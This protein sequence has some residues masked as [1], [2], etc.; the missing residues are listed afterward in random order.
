MGFP[1]KPFSLTVRPF[2]LIFPYRDLQR[3]RARRRDSRRPPSSRNSLLWSL[4]AVTGKLT[5][6]CVR[7][8]PSEGWW[9]T[10]P[11][12]SPGERPTVNNRER[13]RLSEVRRRSSFPSCH[14]KTISYT[15]APAPLFDAARG[16]RQPVVTTAPAP[17]RAPRAP[18]V[19]I[20]AYRQ[21]SDAP[22]PLGVGLVWFEVELD[23]D[24]W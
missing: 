23:V 21:E 8:P 24:L 22:R 3:L 9:S 1:E 4:P 19:Q 15:S 14:G 12:Y 18:R 11:A 7:G 2:S 20:G 6:A 13:G 17:A 5:G 10:R 16:G